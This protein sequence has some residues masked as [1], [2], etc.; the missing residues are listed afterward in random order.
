MK[1]EGP[2]FLSRVFRS[3]DGDQF[4]DVVSAREHDDGKTHVPEGAPPSDKENPRRIMNESGRDFLENVCLTPGSSAGSVYFLH[5][6]DAAAINR[7]KL[8][9]QQAIFRFFAAYFALE[10][11]VIP[12][13]DGLGGKIAALFGR[14]RSHGALKMGHLP[15]SRID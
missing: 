14:T 12:S 13:A 7:R 6:R 9:F 15:V 1:Q 8:S 3:G 10:M 4:R 5:F 11:D 2:G